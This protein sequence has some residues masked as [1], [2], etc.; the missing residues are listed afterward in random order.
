MSWLN[1]FLRKYHNSPTPLLY[2]EDGAVLSVQ[3]VAN[4]YNRTNVNLDEDV[5]YTHITAYVIV[6]E[7]P[8]SWKNK[9]MPTPRKVCTGH[10]QVPIELV[11]YFIASHGG[12]DYEKT[13]GGED[14]LVK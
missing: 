11:H 3:A 5:V 9:C 12:V 13:L 14:V 6:G 2:L 8:L 10:T 7:M 4:S 1:E